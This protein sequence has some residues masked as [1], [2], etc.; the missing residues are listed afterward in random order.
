[1]PHGVGVENSAKGKYQGSYRFGEKDGYGKFNWAE[2]I[3]Y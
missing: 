1:M 2:G 3:S